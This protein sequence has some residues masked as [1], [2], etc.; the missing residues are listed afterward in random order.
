MCGESTHDS[1]VEQRHG[2][3]MDAVA[4]IR[5]TPAVVVDRAVTNRLIRMGLTTQQILQRPPNLR[6]ERRWRFS[7]TQLWQDP[8][9]LYYIQVSYSYTP[10]SYLYL[11][12][13]KILLLASSISNFPGTF[14]E[15]RWQNDENLKGIGKEH[16]S[17]WGSRVK[18][19]P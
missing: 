12:N 8:E 19:L 5:T 16:I 15:L 4:V 1:Y 17:P 10:N 2:V 11:H 3:Q 18:C 9:L 6:L 7:R 14:E 13:L